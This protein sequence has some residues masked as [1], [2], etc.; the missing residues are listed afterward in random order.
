MRGDGDRR[1][2]RALLAA[3]AFLLAAIASSGC[4]SYVPRPNLVVNAAGTRIRVERLV[5]TVQLTELRLVIE[6]A[7]PGAHLAEIVLARANAEQCRFGWAP[8][9]VVAD[10]VASEPDKPLELRSGQRL[11]V[12]FGAELAPRVEKGV[13]LDLLTSHAGRED[14]VAIPITTG[15]DEHRWH[16][17]GNA[18]SFDTA[19]GGN[20]F[21]RSAGGV[22]GELPITFALARRFGESRVYAG[23]GIGAVF[24]SARTCPPEIMNEGTDNERRSPRVGLELPML[25]GVDTMPWQTGPIAFGFA[26]EYDFDY[27]RLKTYDGMRSEWLQGPLVAP[28]IALTY[29]N[30]DAPGLSGGPALG[31]VALDVPVGVIAEHSDGWTVAPRIGMRLLMSVPF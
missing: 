27:V 19:L 5:R 17:V 9:A 26:V 11:I 6:Y 1:G 7:E 22:V 13:R 29:P 21:T 14:C 3:C 12:S 20:F 18:W 28:R 24:C 31:F 8:T 25:I 23:G 2:S 16:R 10:G 30:P 4:V 15:K